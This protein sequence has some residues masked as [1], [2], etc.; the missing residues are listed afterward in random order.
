MSFTDKDGFAKGKTR[1]SKPV[2]KRIS[3]QKRESSLI[4]SLSEKLINSF[5]LVVDV[6]KLDHSVQCIV[7]FSGV[8]QSQYLSMRQGWRCTL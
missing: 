3:K 6:D 5:C 1:H 7:Q 2:A 4:R 8:A